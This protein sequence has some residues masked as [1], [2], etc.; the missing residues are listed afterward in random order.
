[1]AQIS[2][3]VV[4]ESIYKIDNFLQTDPKLN[5]HVALLAI[6]GTTILVPYL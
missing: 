6:A 4:Q 2:L 1:M 5:G 3:S